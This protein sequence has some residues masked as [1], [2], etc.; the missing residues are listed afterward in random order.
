[1]SKIKALFAG[2]EFLEN[3]GLDYIL[4][5]G[6]LLGAIREKQLIEHDCDIDI[7][8]LAEDITH[9]KYS[10]L[11]EGGNSFTTNKSCNY[12][13]CHISLIFHTIRFDIFPLNRK[14]DQRMFNAINNECLIWPEDLFIKKDW[15]TVNMYERDWNTPKDPERFLQLMYGENWRI[16]DKNFTWQNALNYIKYEKI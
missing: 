13:H 5:G 6:T 11:Q 10:A 12:E 4:V 8:V 15:E 3:I 7:A 9:E 1:M 16:P 2:G 14:K